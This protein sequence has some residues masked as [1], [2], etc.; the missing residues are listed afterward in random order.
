MLLSLGFYRLVYIWF[1]TTAVSDESVAERNFKKWRDQSPQVEIVCIVLYLANY[2]L[3]IALCTTTFRILK[4]RY[5]TYIMYTYTYISCDFHKRTGVYYTYNIK[6][7]FFVMHTLRFYGFVG[8]HVR[9]T[10]LT[11]CTLNSWE[12]WFFT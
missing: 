7:M 6:L 2:I 4:N 12:K 5:F 11:A 3:K 8:L 10:A 1:A 9:F